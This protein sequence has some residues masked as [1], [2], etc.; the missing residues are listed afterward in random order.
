MRN[1]KLLGILSFV[2]ACSACVLAGCSPDDS[3]EEVPAPVRERQVTIADFETW[4][5]G[6]QLIR[7]GQFFGQIRVNSDP[8][9][10]K[11]GKQSAQIHANRGSY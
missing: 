4:E 3:S 2:I 7:T 9:F 1:K 10:V 11:S 8:Q 5:S 6:F